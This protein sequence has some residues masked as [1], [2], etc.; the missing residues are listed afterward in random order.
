MPRPI[1]KEDLLNQGAHNFDKLMAFV[2]ALP[3]EVQVAEF[4][5]GT[6]NRNIRDLLMH[7]HHWHKMMQ[8]WYR[9][10]MAGDKPDMPAKGYTWKTTPEL[11]RWIWEHYQGTSLNKSKA[12]V[13]ESHEAV[14]Q[15]IESHT[16]E[17]L[18]EK[19]RYPWTGST[20][21]RAYFIS[22]TS[23]HYAWALKLIRKAKQIVPA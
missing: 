10:G 22:A 18:F 16:D 12:L 21:L 11:N 17:E 4:P 8:E 20:S 5:P 2:E 13:Q 1:N 14:R 23:S 19:K 15:L 7:L 9:V 3:P 6:M